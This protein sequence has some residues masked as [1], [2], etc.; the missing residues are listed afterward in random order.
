MYCTSLHY[1]STRLQGMNDI[2]NLAST[3]AGYF[4]GVVQYSG[5]NRVFEVSRMSSYKIMCHKDKM[6]MIV[7]RLV[8]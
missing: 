8:L 2:M 1:Y 6:A 3:M 5:D 4:A 7:R